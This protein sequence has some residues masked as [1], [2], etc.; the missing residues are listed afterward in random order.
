MYSYIYMYFIRLCAG[1][2]WKDLESTTVCYVLLFI[3][4]RFSK[5]QAQK[6]PVLPSAAQKRLMP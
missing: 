6:P 3:V 5:P 1:E 4:F 2:H